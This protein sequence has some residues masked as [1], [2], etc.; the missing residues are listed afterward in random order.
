MAVR[1]SGT[2]DGQRVIEWRRAGWI[3]WVGGVIWSATFLAVALFVSNGVLHDVDQH[4]WLPAI[5]ILTM[6]SLIGPVGFWLGAARP[7]VRL[8]PTKLVV[9]NAVRTYHLP[10]ASIEP[11]VSSGAYGL[12]ISYRDSSG[13]EHEVVA[14]AVQ[15]ARLF[16]MTGRR[17]LGDK[18]AEEINMAVEQARREGSSAPS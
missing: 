8:T 12:A 2:E 3:V 5:G 17:R 1:R 14:S 16:L 4:R 13:D 6:M 9:T 10:L 7:R 15:K 18:A 11:R